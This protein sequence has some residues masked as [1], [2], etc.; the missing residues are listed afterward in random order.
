MTEPDAGSDTTSIRTTA[1]RVG[2]GY[3][4]RGQKWKQGH[5]DAARTLHGPASREHEL[6]ASPLSC[7]PGLSPEHCAYEV[8]YIEC[9]QPLF[10]SRRADQSVVRG[11]LRWRL[12]R[13]CV[14][15]VDGLRI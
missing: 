4:V 8:R 10:R 13:Q 3:V 15:R 12:A 5:Y 9:A 14:F 1:E 6:A 7:F 11:A 2:D